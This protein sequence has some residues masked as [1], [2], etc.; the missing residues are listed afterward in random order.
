MK[1]ILA[2]AIALLMVL[3]LCIGCADGGGNGATTTVQQGGE[4]TPGGTTASDEGTTA[5]GADGTT[6]P[7]G[8]ATTDPSGDNTQPP[9][10]DAIELPTEKLNMTVKVLTRG[11][12]W[13]AWDIVYDTS[14]T[15]EVV[16]V[17]NDAIKTRNDAIYAA[18]GV[19][20]EKIV[21][22]GTV[23]ATAEL[24]LQSHTHEY[25]IL[26]PTIAEAGQLAQQGFLIPTDELTYMDTDQAW[27]DQRCLED[28]QI[29][30]KNYFFLSDIT[31][32]DLDAIWTFFFNHKMI[33]DYGLEN[34]YELV[35]NYDVD[36]AEK[37][38]YDK[39]LEMC[40]AVTPVRAEDTPTKTSGW[41]IVGHDY[42]IT[43]VYIG[44]GERVATADANGDISLT[45]NNNSG[46]VVN[47]MEKLIE[48]KPYWC[49]YGLTSNAYAGDYGPA[50]RYGFEPGD[51]YPELIGV[52][53]GGHSL[54]LGEVLSTLRTN[55][56][57]ETDLEIGVLP[58]P[59]FDDTQKEYY[60]AVND[61]A[62]AMAIPITSLEI[63]K[64]SII[65]EAWARESHKTLLP[66]YYDNCMTNRY[67]KDNITSDILDLI[68]ESRTYDLGIY[69]GW[70]ELANR[71]TA[72]TYAS[73]T[74]FSSMYRTHSVVAE[75]Q[76]EEFVET[77]GG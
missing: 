40:E 8:G 43:S 51:D 17:L 4:Q 67:A 42:I 9:V 44:S 31:A 23:K 71:F 27:Y 73:K 28:L 18:Y 11:N 14:E 76:L 58:T 36:G 52:F 16:D 61:K 12:N 22:P 25:D 68:F 39:M 77:F 30:G 54:F 21:A 20:F 66:A 33:R 34:P 41:G 57:V 48:L 63:E 72:L 60:C 15:P 32:V 65:V 35:A 3:P 38:T 59:M 53:T 56:F 62:S 45:M 10:S 2:L 64:M 29:K 24:K 47:I 75:M 7:D 49:R 70:G 69:Y 19:D 26:L 37:W 6:A 50:E 13:G 1:K 55:S 74:N 46:R 5:P